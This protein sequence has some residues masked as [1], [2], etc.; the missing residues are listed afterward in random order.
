MGREVDGMAVSGVAMTG[1]R[2]GHRQR[3]REVVGVW[4]AMID[5]DAVA[6]EITM[7]EV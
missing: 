6:P 1:K 4:S 2:G 7:L 5:R 3:V